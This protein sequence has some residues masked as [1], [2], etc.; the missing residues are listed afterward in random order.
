MRHY[1]KLLNV[2]NEKDHDIRERLRYINQLEINV[3]Y[4]FLL[5]VL[6]HYEE[7]LINKPALVNIISLI[8]SFV[9]RRFLVGVPTNALNKVF[10]RLYEDIDATDYVGSLSKSL[11]RKKSSQRFP[12]RS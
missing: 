3:S 2:E 4:P 7:G 1:T 5:Q 10:I 6:V 9:W 12:R 11:L 8:E